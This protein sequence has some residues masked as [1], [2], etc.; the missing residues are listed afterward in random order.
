MQVV[1]A[2]L[3]LDLAALEHQLRKIAAYLQFGHVA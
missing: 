2:G 1:D 3:I